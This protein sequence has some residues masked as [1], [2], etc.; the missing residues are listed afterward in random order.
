MAEGFIYIL[1]NE[2]MPGLLKIGMTTQVPME[3][4]RDLHTTGVPAP[5]KVELTIYHEDC[6][7]MERLI[8]LTLGQSRH[9]QRREF[10]RIDLVEA[11]VRVSEIVLELC[12]LGKD[13]RE[14]NAIDMPLSVGDR[15][16]SDTWDLH[17]EHHPNLPPDGGWSPSM[18]PEWAQYLKPSECLVLE[19]RR[20]REFNN[21]L[22]S[23]AV[24]RAISLIEQSIS[25]LNPKQSSLVFSK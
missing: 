19:L 11:K 7:K 16:T 14:S 2:T 24:K 20:L 10:F 25:Q 23:K 22:H 1:R 15:L 5:F 3:R 8:H 18:A 17:R 13:I 9:S 21:G 6:V 12:K 4:A